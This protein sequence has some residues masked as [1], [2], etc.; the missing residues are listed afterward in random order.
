MD[1]PICKNWSVN[2]EEKLQ[3]VDAEH[4]NWKKEKKKRSCVEEPLANVCV[5]L[6]LIEKSMQTARS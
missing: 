1:Y 2:S 5:Y 6:K 3:C 4:F